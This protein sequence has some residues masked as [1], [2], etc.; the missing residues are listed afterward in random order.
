LPVSQGRLPAGGAVALALAL[1]RLGWAEDWRWLD[2]E[3]RGG[4]SGTSAGTLLEAARTRGFNASLYNHGGFDELKSA[5]TQGHSVMAMVDVGPRDETGALLPGSPADLALQWVT[6]SKAFVDD[7]GQRWVELENPEGT[8]ERL[9]YERFEALWRRVSA[10]G[11]PT[12]YDRAWLRI[13]KA[14]GE[15]PPST[16]GDVVGISAFAQGAN[17]IVRGLLGQGA[18]RVIGGVARMVAALPYAAVD[19]VRALF[20]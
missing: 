2:R 3:V 20:S 18:G 11:L 5:L 13:A 6:V 14:G 17:D 4:A 16:A 9:K 15:L 8:R 1:D 10:A 7:G 19:W 12:G